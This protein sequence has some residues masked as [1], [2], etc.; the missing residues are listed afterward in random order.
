MLTPSSISTTLARASPTNWVIVDCRFDL[1]DPAKGEQLYL[2]SHIPGA[3]YAHLDRDLSG[4]EDGHERPAS[5]ADSGADARAVRRAWHRARHAGRRVR[6]RQRHVCGAAVVDAALHGSRRRGRA[7]RRLRAL[8]A[9]RARRHAAGVRRRRT[10]DIHGHAARGWRARRRRRGRTARRPDA[11]CWSTPAPRRASA[12]KASRST[13]VAGHIPGARNLLLPAQSDRRQD[14]QEPPTSSAREWQTLSEAHRPGPGR[15][16]LRLRGDGLPQPA[17]PG[18]RRPSRRPPLP[19][20]LE[21]MVR[22]IPT[23]RSRRADWTQNCAPDDL[24][25]SD[26]QP[27]TS[28]YPPTSGPALVQGR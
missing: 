6:R 7:R 9:R 18:T 21:R 1:A 15:D 12:A 10:G 26:G 13:R 14:L 28:K 25:A 20:L 27:C 24:P 8:G 16:V 3:R 4:D 2:E 19:R 11:A 22:A 5:A 17:R 23:G